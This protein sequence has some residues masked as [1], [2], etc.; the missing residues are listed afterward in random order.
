MHAHGVG[1]LVCGHSGEGYRTETFFC[2]L[3][4]DFHDNLHLFSIYP[5]KSLF[6]IMKLGNFERASE[7]GQG[8]NVI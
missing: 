7:I 4:F 6:K 8:K 3:Y 5:R 1:K 2:I